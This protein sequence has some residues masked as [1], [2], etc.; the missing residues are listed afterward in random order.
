[1]ITISKEKKKALGYIKEINPTEIIFITDGEPSVAA[2]EIKRGLEAFFDVKSTIVDLPPKNFKNSIIRIID[3][4]TPY[5]HE[6]YSII[7]VIFE[8]DLET[9][10][11]LIFGT[12]ISDA[13]SE[14]FF[15]TPS[16][17]RINISTLVKAFTMSKIKRDLL[18]IMAKQRFSTL[19]EL[20]KLTGKAKTTLSLQLK[21]LREDGLIVAEQTGKSVKFSLNKY[22]KLFLKPA[23]TIQ[24]DDIGVKHGVKHANR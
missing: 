16:S 22:S 13:S 20:S 11:A 1:V 2:K 23:A 18:D 12:L 6:K 7:L 15:E 4:L 14:I 10:L 21:E 3:L 9:T 5:T 8:R 24:N 19:E 17:G